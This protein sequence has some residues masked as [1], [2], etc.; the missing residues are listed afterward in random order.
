MELPSIIAFANE[1]VKK[2]WNDAISKDDKLSKSLLKAKEDLQKN[3]YAGQ[4]IKKDLIPKKYKHYSN[5]WRYELVDAWRL[6]YSIGRD[7]VQVLSIVLEWGSH[8]EY[9]R[10]FGY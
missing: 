7:Q 4:Q 10:L 9:D 1:K 3:A 6:I 2:E 8:K 5:L